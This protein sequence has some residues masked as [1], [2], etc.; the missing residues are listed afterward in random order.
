MV[1]PN[2]TE[3]VRAIYD[4]T[5]ARYDQS[6]NFSEKF[7]IGDGRAWACSQARGQVLELAIGTGRN[8]SFYA[9]DVDLTAIELSL[10][11][12]EVT[13]QRARD[14]KRQVELVNGDAQ[15]LPFPD[16]S[17]DTVV[18]TLALCTIPDE[19][20]AVA[21][22]WRVLRPGGRFIA[23]EHVRSPNVIVRGIEHLLEPL[24]VRTE[25]DHLLREPVEAVQAAGFSIEYLTRHKLGVIERLIARKAAQ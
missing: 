1:S 16:Q 17:F 24:S 12:L 4:S 15:A 9:E 14:L 22:V 10:S 8:L 2:E 18:C 20:K 6:M 13:R 11:M 19:R 7:F 21:E 5:A 3:R 25:A 23:L